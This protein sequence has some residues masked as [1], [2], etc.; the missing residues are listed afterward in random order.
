[1]TPIEV[2]DVLICVGVWIELG[3]SAF[4]GYM[5]W[6]IMTDRQK[7]RIR[8]TVNGLFKYLG[9]VAQEKK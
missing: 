3:I 8:R 6:H 9:L 5:T 1:M 2:I 4:I 7:Q